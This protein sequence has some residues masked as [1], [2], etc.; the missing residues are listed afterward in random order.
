[1][2]F[3]NP[4]KNVEAL[5]LIPGMTVADFGSGSGQYSLFLARAVGE[6]G[7]V[8][9]IDVQKDLLARL[10]QVARDNKIRNIECLWGDL[11]RP[12]GSKLA[13]ESISAVVMSNILFQVDNQ[14]AVVKEVAR[15]LTMG[16]KVLVVDWQD[17]FG[18]LGPAPSQ[19]VKSETA[20]QIFLA[21]GFSLIREFSAGEHH[22][23]L[24]LEKIKNPN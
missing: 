23:G 20:K 21:N 14:E 6:S 24:I 16:G 5:S 3:A 19:I 7:R 10:A 17:S 4:E 1:M 8:Y 2:N 9:A 13:K 12:G 15:V 18:N 22:Y 11:E